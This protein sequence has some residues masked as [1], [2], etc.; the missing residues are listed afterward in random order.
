MLMCPIF[1][2]QVFDDGDKLLEYHNDQV[3]LGI[4]YFLLSKD[5]V[6]L[7]IKETISVQS[8]ILKFCDIRI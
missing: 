1:F 7:N 8:E 3:N 5:H 2:L 4:I 6:P